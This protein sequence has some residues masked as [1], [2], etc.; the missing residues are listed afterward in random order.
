[1]FTEDFA[2]ATF[3]ELLTGAHLALMADADTEITGTGYA[4]QDISAAF[5]TTQSEVVAGETRYFRVNTAE[6][7]FGI[8]GGNWNS[9]NPIP[10]IG[11]WSAD[12]A[13][14]LRMTQPITPRTALNGGRAVR[15]AAGR[16][17]L[18]LI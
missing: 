5:G 7:T 13:G 3:D 4:R 2:D 14:D 18:V 8:P 10:D 15:F 16:L 9:S 12:T 6:I 17:K 11:I 1:M